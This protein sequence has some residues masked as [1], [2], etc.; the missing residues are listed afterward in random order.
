MNEQQLQKK[1]Q[2][3]LKKLG[4]YHF[5]TI[6]S[7]RAGVPDLIACVPPE[8]IFLGLEVKVGKNKASKLQEHHI[9]E[10]QKAGGKAHVVWSLEEVIE[11]LEQHNLIAD[12]KA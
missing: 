8:G 10:I 3:Y 1:I 9:N 2:N 7:N 12:I 6:S 11:L 4:I 5:K